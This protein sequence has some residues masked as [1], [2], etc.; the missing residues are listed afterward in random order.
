MMTRLNIVSKTHAHCAPARESAAPNPEPHTPPHQSRAEWAYATT[1][2]RSASPPA[3]SS[4]ARARDAPLRQHLNPQPNAARV[5]TTIHTIRRAD[6]PAPAPC[7]W[8]ACVPE[9]T[10]ARAV[11]AA[12]L[13]HLSYAAVACRVASSLARSLAALRV[14]VLRLRWIS[15]VEMGEAPRPKSPPRYPDLCG[16][17]R[18]QLEMQILNREVGFLEQELQGLERIQPVSSVNEFVGA[19]SDPLIPISKLCNCLLCLCCWCR[20]LPKPK[21][22]SC[23]SCSCCSCCDTSCCRPSCGC[24]KAPSSCCCKS[25]CSLKA[26]SSCCCKSNCSCCS[27]DCC[28]CSLPSCG[29][30]GCG[31]CRPRCGGGGGCCPPSDCCSSCKCSCSSCTRCCSSCAGGCKPSCSGC[32]TG[33]SSCGG[34]CCPK[35]SSCAAPCVGCLAL[36][37]RWL[38]CRSSCC[39]GQPSCCK[40]QSSCCEGEPSCCCCCGGGKGSSAC[41]CGRPCCLGGATPAPSCPECSCGCSCSCPRCKDGCSCPSCGNPCCAGGCLC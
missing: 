15:W 33:C 12:L 39:K 23:F 8:R 3:S 24:L 37:R 40:C 36:L 7:R 21:K 35:C 2:T 11:G 4:R 10:V 19:K 28:T 18:L 22:P 32:G 38:S 13:A 29:C 20:C 34:G 41:C 16:R 27:S 6:A 14:V 26:P 30:T 9:L 31:H 25:N 5:A 17:R 1:C